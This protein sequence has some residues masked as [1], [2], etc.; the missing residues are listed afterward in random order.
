M[1][2]RQEMDFFC[3]RLVLKGRDALKSRRWLLDF[4][5][6]LLHATGDGE[7]L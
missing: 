5:S 1:L 6:I 4:P 7:Q 3:H 2:Q